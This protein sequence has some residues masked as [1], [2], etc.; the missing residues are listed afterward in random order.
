MQTLMLD[1]NGNIWLPA[2]VGQVLNHELLT[3]DPSTE[4]NYILSYL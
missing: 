3:P 4:Q 1:Q 2:Y